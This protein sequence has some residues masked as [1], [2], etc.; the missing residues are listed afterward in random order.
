MLLELVGHVNPITDIF[1]IFT[2]IELGVVIGL[3]L[4]IHSS[5][6]LLVRVA[7]GGLRGMLR[8]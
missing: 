6:V 8:P 2:E 7:S 3:G 1:T 4:E 5:Q